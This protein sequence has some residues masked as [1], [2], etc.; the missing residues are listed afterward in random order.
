MAGH[1]GIGSVEP[2]IV[3]IG[4]G[5]GGLEIIADHELR[6]AAEILE[7]IGM[8]A[9][10]V[11]QALAWASLGVGV[12]RGPH[13]RDE[14]LHGAHFAGD[15][16]EDVDGVAGE[17]DEHLLPTDVGLTHAR[18][19]TLLPGLEGR[20]KPGIAK[21]VGIGGAILF[22]QQQA[23][24]A[25]AAQFLLHINPIGCRSPV[26]LRGCRR[27]REQQ[28]LQALVVHALR[29]WPAQPRKACAP[30]ITMHDAIAHSQHLRDDAL[31]QALMPQT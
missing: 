28:Q 23:C 15:G 19:R 1:L 5:H 9:D 6:H 14:Q 17:I 11:G 30:H 10:P 18:A 24:H 27:R 13:R 8:H 2:G 16:I 12:V 20:A 25:A 26:A 29:Q 22:P 3:A 7:Q 21:A 31:G 4:V